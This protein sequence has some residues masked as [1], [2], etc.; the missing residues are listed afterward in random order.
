MCNQDCRK[1]HGH[2]ECDEQQH[3]RY[4]SHNICVQHRNVGDTQHK[5]T[6]LAVHTLDSNGS[7]SSDHGCNQR[8]K[9]C[10]DQGVVQ[11]A[12]DRFILEKGYIPFSGKSAPFGTGSGTVKGQN[13]QCH[14]RSIEE[15]HD[16]Q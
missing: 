4:T 9:K 6:E 15:D 3:H 10:D 12:H 16:Q 14:D 5:G 13:H 11:G 8:R 1:S 7:Q 2:T